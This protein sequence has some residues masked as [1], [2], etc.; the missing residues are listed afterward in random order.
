MPTG[1][2]PRSGHFWGQ[3][4]HLPLFLK[5]SQGSGARHDPQRETESAWFVLSSNVKNS[6]V[7][8]SNVKNSNV[9]NS[10]VKNSNVKNSNT[11]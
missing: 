9:K 3:Q 7:K 1:F 11:K 4:R 6:N 10:N 2:V 5:R 8:N